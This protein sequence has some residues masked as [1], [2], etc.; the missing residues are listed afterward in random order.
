[1][2]CSEAR[3]SYLLNCGRCTL[4]IPAKRSRTSSNGDGYQENAKFGATVV[5]QWITNPT[6][7]LEDMGLIPGLTQ[8]VEDP[9]LP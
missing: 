3:Q 4:D 9:S 6:S 1:M 7:I 5:A 8:W 2:G